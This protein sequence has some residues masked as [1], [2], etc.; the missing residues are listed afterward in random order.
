MGSKPIKAFCMPGGKLAFHAG[1]LD[2]L[3]VSDNQVAMAAEA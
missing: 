2:P 1:L 3:Q